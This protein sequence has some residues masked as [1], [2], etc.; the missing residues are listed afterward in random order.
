MS[1]A[2]IYRIRVRGHLLEQWSDWFGL[3]VYNRPDGDAELRGIL[4]DQAALHAVLRQ[5]CNLG[6]TLIAVER[7]EAA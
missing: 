1:D 6:L 5:I 3:C 4:P 2:A 7:V